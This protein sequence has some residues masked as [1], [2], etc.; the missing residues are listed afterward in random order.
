[1]TCPTFTKSLYFRIP[2][3]L[4][5]LAILAGIVYGIILF[6]KTH[7]DL[8]NVEPDFTITASGLYSAFEADETAATE[9]Y[10]GKV[11]E[12]NGFVSQ[13]EYISTSSTLNITLC[14]EDQISG[15]ICTFNDFTDQSLVPSLGG[16]VTARGEC[17]GMLMD[18]LLNNCVFP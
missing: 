9:K 1:M 14:D 8:S 10:V 11:I 4:T 6:T 2:A 7:S 15:V 13:V 3:A 17:S 16:N 5:M 12:V 18:V